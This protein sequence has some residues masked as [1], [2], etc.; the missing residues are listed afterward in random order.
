MASI[1]LDGRSLD[2]ETLASVAQG[3]VTL[4]LGPEA[5]R[6]LEASH[7]VVLRILQGDAQVYGVN[8][9]FGH[10]KDIRIPPDQLEALQ[11][12]LIRSHCAGVGEPLDP[13]A[14]RVLM[15]LRAHVLARGHSGVRPLVVETLLGHLNADL[16][17]IVPQQGSVG[18]SGDLAPLA[19]LALLL[20]GEGEGLLRG[21]RLPAA[22][23]QRR[24]GLRPLVLGP[25]EGLALINGTQMTAAIG[26]LAL[27]EA[28]DAAALADLAGACS[29]EALKGSHRA[30]DP[31]I[32]EL[33]PHPGQIA[34][35]SNLR[36]L[37]ADSEILR[38]HDGCGRV[39]D[40]YSL[41]CMPQVHGAARE[42]LS[43]TGSVLG[44]EINAVTD[45]PIVFPESG[46]LLS[47]GNFHG[48]APAL[49][50]DA[51]AM[52]AAEIASISERRIE[53]LMNPAL[54]GLPPFLTRDPGVNSGLMM[55]Q[56]TAAALVS[57]NKVLCH[58]ASVDSIPTEAGQEDHVS[59]GP[60]AARKART[61]VAHARRVLAIELLCACQALDLLRPLKPGRGVAAA[62][63]RVRRDVPF[64]ET[65]RVLASD[66]RDVEALLASG[67]VRAAAESA[68]GRLQ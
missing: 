47:G 8:T 5:R 66:I 2:F 9:G 3:G 16:L 57:E 42:V 68:S 18:A 14:T 64:M 6:G 32:H 40:A 15:L 29:L 7:A 37:L 34:S 51:L 28:R 44:I 36:A 46:D 26:A 11:R 38:S 54:S 10:L 53:R 55:A 33:R 17:P 27:L 13:P 41:R 21:E 30:F 35:A 50:L 24:A 52:A 60:W 39:Q 19:H 67:A 45:N 49:A 61:V 20:L 1:V 62:F 48:E 58:P 25:K 4:S 22:E 43:F 63:D 65:D 59:M 31:R 56:V 12:N 23:A